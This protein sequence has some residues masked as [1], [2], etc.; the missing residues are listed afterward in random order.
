MKCS[1][2][3]KL[4]VEDSRGNDY[5]IYRLRRCSVCKKEFA[6]KEV[7]VDYE[8]GKRLLHK[9]HS[10]KYGKREPFTKKKRIGR[11]LG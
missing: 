6:T 11:R 1:C 5:V 3:G 4:L 7:K 9:I 8:E 10:I 2:G